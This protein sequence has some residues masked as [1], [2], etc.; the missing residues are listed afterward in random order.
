MKWILKEKKA[1]VSEWGREIRR[2]FFFSSRRRRAWSSC[3]WSSDVCS[4]DLT[5]LDA[6]EAFAS[7]GSPLIVENFRDKNSDNTVSISGVFVDLSDEDLEMVG[8][9]W[10]Y[11]DDRYGECIRVKWEWIAPGN[12]DRK[13]AV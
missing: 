8:Q 9:K 5:V 1:S 11:A 7:V 12:K 3:D 2:G 10:K 6:Y 4:S 13:S